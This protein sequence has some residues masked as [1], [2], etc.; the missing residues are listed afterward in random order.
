MIRFPDK[1]LT[2]PKIHLTALVDI[3]FLLL[4]FFLL[5]SN[6]VSQQGISIIVPEVASE[7]TELLPETIVDIDQDGTLYFDGIQVNKT[8]LLNLLKQHYKDTPER[9]VAIHADRRV[10]YD[11]VAQVID[12]AKLAGVNNFL[13]ITKEKGNGD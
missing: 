12:I 7:G 2:R 8:I 3:V 13:L 11:N 1:K 6:F 9:N 5:S 4:I 10:P